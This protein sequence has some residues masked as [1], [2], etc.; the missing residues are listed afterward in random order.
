MQALCRTGLA[1]QA[2]L[3]K[4]LTAEIIKYYFY[5]IGHEQQVKV[6]FVFLDKNNVI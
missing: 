2:R 3:L 6:I 1:I 4:F 5:N